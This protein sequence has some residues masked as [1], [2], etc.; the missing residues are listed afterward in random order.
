[1]SKHGEI[2]RYITSLET[3]TKISV[4]SIANALKVSDGTAYRAIKECDTLGIVTTVPRVGT[5]RIDKVK[6]ESIE[7]LNYE[8]VVKIVDGLVLGGQKGITKTLNRFLIGA[9]TSEAANRYIDPNCLLIVGNREDIQRLALLNDCAVLIAGGFECSEDIKNLANERGL[10]VISSAYDTF[11][12]ATMIN[13]AISESLIKKDIV[14]VEDVMETHFNKVYINDS[15][16]NLR[17]LIKETG[18]SK[19]T[20]LDEEGK[21][22]GIVHIKDIASEVSGSELI[23]D[24]VNNNIS[25]VGPKTT[26]AYTAH[27]MGW[28]D[29][30]LC[31]VVDDE[32]LIGIVDRQTVIK[33]LQYSSKQPQVGENL[34]DMVLKNFDFHYNEDGIHFTGKIVPE[35]LDNIGIASWSSMNMLLSTMG[36]MTL[37]QNRSINVSVDSIMTY[38]I[39]PVQIESVIDIYAKIVDLGRSFSKVEVDMYSEERELIAKLMLSGKIFNKI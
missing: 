8:E 39:K 35:M 31:A 27:V 3:G 30:D 6:K 2:I 10:P 25:T 23:K 34:E 29:I 19:Y 32:R 21:V 15:V 22:V 17:K 37:R 33:A 13:K 12:I 4:R 5:V 7:V 18:I 38:F 28:E 1:M 26:I 14:L 9:M 16:E 36:I 11:T 20:V 24:F